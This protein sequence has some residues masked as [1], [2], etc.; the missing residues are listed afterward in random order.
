MATIKKPESRNDPS[1]RKQRSIAGAQE[2]TLRDYQDVFGGMIP[3]IE[4]YVDD[5]LPK[6]DREY[7]EAHCTSAGLAAWIQSVY[8]K[9]NSDAIRGVCE[10]LER[11]ANDYRARFIPSEN[12]KVE[13]GI[14]ESATQRA[15]KVSQ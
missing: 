14:K 11:L 5:R 15:G 8:A 6:E 4:S 12:A 3:L 2:T 9:K 1:L 13:Y 10:T 7:V